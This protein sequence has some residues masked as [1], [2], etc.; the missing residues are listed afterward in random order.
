MSE[1]ANAALNVLPLGDKKVFSLAR[2]CLQPAD[3]VP[4]VLS[5][6]FRFKKEKKASAFQLAAKC[7]GT[8]PERNVLQSIYEMGGERGEG[9]GAEVIER[10]RRHVRTKVPSGVNETWLSKPRKG[11]RK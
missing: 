7:Q 10:K 3:L 5:Q 2:Q 6:K 1:G 9:L 8:V 4:S 11:Y